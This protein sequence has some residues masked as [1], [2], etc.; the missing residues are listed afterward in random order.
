M[1]KWKEG[2]PKGHINKRRG[3]DGGHLLPLG[4]AYRRLHPFPFL[5]WEK[6]LFLLVCDGGLEDGRTEGVLD[7]YHTVSY[8]S[9]TQPHVLYC[10][11]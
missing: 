2:G 8:F 3:E 10:V 7:Y 9:V 11:T 6:N 4:L 1:R 5:F